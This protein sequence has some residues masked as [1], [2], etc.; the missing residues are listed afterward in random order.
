MNYRVIYKKYLAEALSF[1]GFNYYKFYDESNPKIVKYS[2]VE[3]EEYLTILGL[4][5]ELK[6]KYDKLNN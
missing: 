2:F 4:D 3:T 1:L 6:G 5:L